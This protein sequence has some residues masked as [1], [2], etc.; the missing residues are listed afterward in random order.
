M[1]PRGKLIRP[2]SPDEFRFDRAMSFRTGQKVPESG[3]YRVIHSG[4]RLPHEVTL[5]KDQQFPRCSKCSDS[6][7]FQVVAL[8]PSMGDRR[9]RIVLYELP[10]LSLDSEQRRA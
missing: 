5:L 7:E 4:H 10:V 2:S 8:A 3:I 6:V 9:G 1:A